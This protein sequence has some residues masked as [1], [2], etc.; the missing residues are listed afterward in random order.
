MQVL[1]TDSLGGYY[2]VPKL[3]RKIREAAIPAYIF[4]QFVAAKEEAIGKRKG[5]TVYWD[6]IAQLSTGGGK[7][8]ETA[9][10]PS[11]S[12]KVVQKSGTISEYGNGIPWTEKLQ[13]LADF[14]VNDIHLRLLRN[15][16]NKVL[17]SACATQFKAGQ[18]YAVCTT[19]S[20]TV[21]TTN[22]AATATAS[23]SM[24]DKN[25][26]DIVDYMVKKNIPKYGNGVDYMAIVSVNSKR[27]LYDYLEAKMQYTTPEY[28]F[29]NEVGRYYNT[30][31]VE[32]N[33]ILSNSKGS[34]TQHGEAIFFG[35][36]AVVE[37][38]AIPEE[39][40]WDPASDLGR[41]RKAGWVAETEW[42]KP[43]DYSTN[44]EE[45]IVYV[46]SGG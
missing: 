7:L 11:D 23:C 17:D 22:G 15:D 39:I 13:T 27:G 21:F 44:T 14:D 45:H 8:T 31:F 32:E 16:Y 9:T 2:T 41:S 28:M 36:D 38:L 40:R 42:V 24:S 1:V 29:N 25:V 20:S 34:G 35:D 30:R 12:Y 19:T 43:W 4:R 18:L 37:L 5:Q 3:S 6:Q 10:V 33:A 46:T 26:R